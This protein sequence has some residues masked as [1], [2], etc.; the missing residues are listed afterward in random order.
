M[1]DPSQNTTSKK[2]DSIDR[3]SPEGDLAKAG[4]DHGDS[5]IELRGVHKAFGDLQVLKGVDLDVFKGENVVVLGRSGSGKSVLIRIIAGLLR[6]DQGSVRVMGSEIDT[7]GPRE[8]RAL[9][10]KIGFSFQS[11]ALYDSMNVR[12]NLEF[13][14]VRNKR[15]LTRKEIDE[16]VVQVLDDV[17]LSQS[18]NQ[19][20]SELS[21]GQKKRIGIARTLILKPEIMLYDEP[22]AGLDPVT[23]VEINDL[24]REVQQRYNTSAVIITHDLTCARATGDRVIM[25]SEGYFLRQGSFDEVFASADPRIQHFYSYNF[26]TK[27]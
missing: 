19:M 13:P 2:P 21:G 1:P 7:L 15:E 26:I 11:S 5:V 6:P 12:A 17:G 22:T 18:I 25:L 27:A 3:A 8:L 4:I 9:R 24:I 14:L 23:S 10:S 20:P 16:A